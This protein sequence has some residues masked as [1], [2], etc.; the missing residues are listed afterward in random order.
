MI[1]PSCKGENAP[2]ALQCAHCRAALPKADDRVG[3]HPD[4]EDRTIDGPAPSAR[5]RPQEGPNVSILSKT[6][7]ETFAVGEL[8]EG[9]TKELIPAGE[10]FDVAIA[11]VAID[12]NLELVG[13]EKVYELGEDGSAK[14]HPLPPDKRGSSNTGPNDKQKLKS[15][16]FTGTLY[17]HSRTYSGL[18]TLSWDSTGCQSLLM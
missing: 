14:I 2:R 7:S 9:Q 17:L 16:N 3:P 11:L 18:L 13:R 10:F 8:S 1:C 15:K 6:P 5:P 12:T 4:Q